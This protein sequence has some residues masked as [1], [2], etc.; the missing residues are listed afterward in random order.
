MARQLVTS[1][2]AMQPAK[3]LNTVLEALSA[4]WPSRWGRPEIEVKRRSGGNG[5]DRV[6]SVRVPNA[7][8]PATLAVNIKP[9]WDGAAVEQMAQRAQ[10]MRGVD[11]ILIAARWIS[12][13]MR[14]LLEERGLNYVDS[15]GNVS[16]ALDK[17]RLYLHAEGA[18]EDPDP[19]PPSIRGLTGAGG[20]TVARTLLDVQPPYTVTELAEDTNLSASFVSRV[21]QG[22]ERE[23]VITRQPRGPVTDVDVAGL[24]KRWA[25]EYAL[26]DT[27][28]CSFYVFPQGPRA[29]ESQLAEKATEPWAVSGS[30]GAVRIAPIAAPGLAVA[31]VEDP[32]A[33]AQRLDLLPADS[34]ANVLLVEP[35]APIAFERR[36]E[37]DGIRYV[38]VSQLAVDCLTGPGRMPSEGE[39]VL[40]W[41]EANADVWRTPTFDE[42]SRM[43]KG[44]W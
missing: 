14:A 24:V 31:Y 5:F 34:G 13:R 27:N 18:D 6:L 32:I 44:A 39:E 10:A 36:W 1:R 2:L 25:R 22:L 30:L 29:F 8:R 38:A 3:I 12:P 15:T 4:A 43:T 7:K 16:I 11:G 17:P 42:P 21:L 9:R 26:Q 33:L 20:A 19:Q 28:V 41:M 35:Y 40:R 23:G 37:R